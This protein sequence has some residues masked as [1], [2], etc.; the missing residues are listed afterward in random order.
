MRAPRRLA[1]ALGLAVAFVAAGCGDEGPAPAHAPA[2]VEGPDPWAP[3]VDPPVPTGPA[4]RVTRAPD[5]GTPWRAKGSWSWRRDLR[6]RLAPE[7]KASSLAYE[8]TFSLERRVVASAGARHARVE[9]TLALAAASSGG[10]RA[11]PLVI[12]FE[13][14][15]DGFGK[16]PVRLSAPGLEDPTALETL[17]AAVVDRFAPPD[18]DVRVGDRF[19]PKEAMALDEQLVRPLFV[20]FQRTLTTWPPMLPQPTGAV[21]VAAVDGTGPAASLV[22]RAA[23]RSEHEGDTD[24]PPLPKE[25]V[26]IAVVQ[27]LEGTRRLALSTGDVLAHDVTL[28]RRLHFTGAAFDYTVE[29]VGRTTLE[30]TRTP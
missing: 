6:G 9:G 13:Q 24:R 15:A 26:H 8:G 16:A 29:V 12:T 14:D 30:G 4:V 2:P 19:A 10:A 3:R 5:P 7:V 18:R 25:N 21:W 1:V 27:A 11:V 17:Q 28:R 20:L 23:V 22:L